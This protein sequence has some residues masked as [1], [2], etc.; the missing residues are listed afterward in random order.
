MLD[1]KIQPLV[2]GQYTVVKRDKAQINDNVFIATPAVQSCIAV[3]LVSYH[4]V[5]LGHFDSI[6][7]L[8]N[9][10]TQMIHKMK[11]LGNSEIKAEL[12]GGVYGITPQSTWLISD[13]IIK[14]FNKK[15]ISYEHKHYSAYYVGF[16]TA[17]LYLAS[18]LL[19]IVGP[20]SLFYSMPLCLLLFVGGSTAESWMRTDQHEVIVNVKTGYITVVKNNLLVCTDILQKTSEYQRGFFS[21]R[22]SKDPFTKDD[23]KYEEIDLT[24]T[25]RKKL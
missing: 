15:K 3:A 4:A 7:D 2:M 14:V 22:M 21:Q 11:N 8:E 23:L 19:G 20:E 5:G 12:I 24:T 1:E 17:S 6:Y 13:T 25:L 18:N 10:L 9:A 16:S